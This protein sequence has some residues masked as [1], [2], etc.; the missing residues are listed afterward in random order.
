MDLWGPVDLAVIE[1]YAYGAGGTALCD[2]AELGGVVR[3]ELHRADVPWIVVPPA[4]LKCYA[5]GKATANKTEMVIAARERLAYAGTSHD[6]A[7]ALWLRAIG[8]DL[9]DVP[10]IRLPQSHR[11]VLSRLTWPAGVGPVA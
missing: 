8:Y 2:L 1:G 11:K 9:L 4:S 6:E 5:T 3:W 10:V 7:D